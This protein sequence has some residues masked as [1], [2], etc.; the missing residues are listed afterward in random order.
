MDNLQMQLEN[1]PK[2]EHKMEK[3]EKAT[4][5]FMQKSET[6]RVDGIITI[7]VVFHVV[8]NNSA[9]NIPD[10]QLITQLN[11]LNEDF[12]RL[13]SDADNTWSQ[14]D[15]AEI[16]FCLATVDPQGAAT[17]GITRTSTSSTSFG[18][19][20]QVKFASSGGKDA[21]PAA[22][23]LNIWV[24]D[25]TGGILGYAQFPG[26]PA[27]TD[28]VVNDYLYTGGQGQ[29]TA[30]FDLGRTLTHEVGHYLNLRHIWGDGGCGV[31]DFVTDTPTSDAS[32][33]GCATGHVSCGT[34]DMVQNYMDY[35][36][37]AC[38]NL[39]TS[40]QKVRMRAIFDTGGFRESLLTSTACGTP[41]EPT[42]TD[43]IQNGQET[44]VDC[45]GPD[46]PTCPPTPTCTDGIQNGDETGID[47]GGSECP[48]CPCAGTDVNVTIT[49]DNYPEETSWSITDGNGSTVAQGGT[50]A[51]QADGSTISI[52]LC[53]TDGC[54]DFIINDTYGDGICCSYGNGSYTV[55]AGGSTAAS[56][57]NFNASETT[58]FCVGGGTGPTCSDGIQNGNETGVDCGGPDCPSCPIEPTCTDG[59]QNGSETGVDCG[60]PD[61]DPCPVVP[62]CTDGVQNGSETGV[63]CGG[64]D[65]DPCPVVPT[66]T[67]GIQ[68]GSET[69]VDCGGPDC[70]PCNPGTCTT[71]N[72]DFNDFENGF[73]IWND[74][75]SDCSLNYSSNYAASGNRSIRLRDNSNSST[76][77]TDNLSLA[78]YE[79]VVIDFSYIGRS[80]ENGEDFWL[81]GSVDG[82][83]TFSTLTS[84]SRGTDF[85]NNSREYATVTITGNF[86]NTT[87]FRFRCD[88]SSNSDFIY[89][90]DIDI[91]G[92]VSSNREII[93]EN[94]LTE[95]AT[96]KISKVKIFPNPTYDLLNI[97]YRSNNVSQVKINVLDMSGR[98]VMTQNSKAVKGSNTEK[99]QVGDLN[100]GIY[101]IHLNNG[102]EQIIKKFVVIK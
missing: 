64:P 57:G 72:V 53:L 52:D 80:M 40:G 2:L 87:K 15:D 94:T 68:N 66:C 91:S 30:P 55:T 4:R 26:G 42:C 19:N 89:L 75:G 82:G 25:I 6:S 43:G 50:Y 11:I 59:I 92:C 8:Y 54:Y 34:V 41:A 38:M 63:D 98:S 3:I 29:A 60:G 99:I 39:F 37:D 13:N 31:D 78:G 1:D 62:T 9:E 24:C 73:G 56:G 51:S 35:S 49:F 71:V 74:G 93:E 27:N 100:A 44:G 5:A 14:A 76:V 69:G 101:Y 10:A 67:D 65:C 95:I 83:S 81:Q 47:C 46:C 23:Y 58:N 61:C 28:G 18:T 90:D 70:D 45:G 84:W 7:P 86:T 33:G 85:N 17:S 102:E 22:D 79:E 36:D 12:R 97:N 96:D 88:A 20:D 16:E 48:S 32:N 21:W 77:T